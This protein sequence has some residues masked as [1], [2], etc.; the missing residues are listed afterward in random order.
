MP[1]FVLWLAFQ[2][3]LQHH[4]KLVALFSLTKTLIVILQESL[5]F[6]RSLDSFSNKAKSIASYGH[7]N[8]PRVKKSVFAI[9]WSIYDASWSYLEARTPPFALSITSVPTSKAE[10]TF[11]TFLFPCCVD[12]KCLVQVKNW[13]VY[14]AEMCSM[15]GSK[16]C[17]VRGVLV[18]LQKGIYHTFDSTILAILVGFSFSFQ[19][20]QSTHWTKVNKIEKPYVG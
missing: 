16:A 20:L 9:R 2:K 5:T 11:Q 19:Q 14:G 4:R 18:V 7:L 1:G 15:V 12:K 3:L 13:K 6:E 17:I 8:K 10:E